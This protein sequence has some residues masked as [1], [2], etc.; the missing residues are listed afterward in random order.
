MKKFTVILWFCMSLIIP[1]SF[2]QDDALTYGL[3]IDEYLEQALP[4]QEGRHIGFDEMSGLLTV[5]DTSSNQR[6]IRQLIKQ[7]DVGPKQILIEAKFVEIEFADLNELGIEWHWYEKGET[8]SN[9]KHLQFGVN[10]DFNADPAGTGDYYGIQWDDSA[11]DDFP[12]SAFGLD[13]FISKTFVS[14]SFVRAY[15]KALA[16]EGRANLLSAPRVVTLNG[17]MANIQVTETI[18]YATDVSL[19]NEGTADHPNWTLTYTVDERLTGITLEVTPYVA[20]DSNIITLD[21]H[22]EVSTLSSRVNIGAVQVVADDDDTATP[23]ALSGL[24]DSL[25]W[26]IIDT[27]T[28][29]TTVNV[30]SGHTVIMGGFVEDDDTLTKKKVPFL[31]DLPLIG[32]LFQYEYQSRTKRNLAIFLTATMITADGEPVTEY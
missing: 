18:P 2:A 13:L 20:E 32:H 21:I 14:D 31:G 24:N 6:L 19:E 15:L 30:K 25:G 1:E 5:T 26:P 8:G 28:T 11:T 10:P 22:P 27:R 7:F 12:Q 17:Q 23:L 4:P 16:S 3:S 9:A 29:Q